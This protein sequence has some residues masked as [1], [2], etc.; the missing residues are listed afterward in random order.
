VSVK[1]R[2]C[3]SSFCT[4]TSESLLIAYVKKCLI[5]IGFSF[6][7]FNPLFIIHSKNMCNSPCNPRT[8]NSQS[9]NL[10]PKRSWHV[11][12][13]EKLEET[14]LL[15]NTLY[16]MFSYQGIT[17]SLQS[18]IDPTISLHTLLHSSM[19]TNLLTIFV[20]FSLY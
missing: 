8:P 17:T 2:K 14:K 20:I 11:K 10:N 19:I 18:K 6:V 3:Q 1:Q 13:H 16:K 12:I 9:V 4:K 7:T 15:R 5:M